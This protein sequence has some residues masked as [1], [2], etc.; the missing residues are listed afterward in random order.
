MALWVRPGATG[1]DGSQA[2]PFGTLT[3]ARDAAR[4]RAATMQG[5]LTINLE[6]GTYVLDETLQLGPEDSGRNG[7]TIVWAAAPGARP[8]VSGGTT[9]TGWQAPTDGSGVWTAKVPADLAIRQLYVD[10]K[11]AELAQGPPPPT[12]TPTA[13]G[14]TAADATMAGWTNPTDIEFVY[15]SGPSNW[16]ESRCRVAAIDG[17]AIT[18]VQPCFD[19]SSK[20]AEG[21]T[22]QV[23]GFGQALPPPKVVA[24]ARELL[25]KPGQWYLDTKA[26]T[27]SYLPLAGQD[28]GKVEVVAPKLETLVAGTGTATSPI[29]DVAFEGITFSYAGWN[30]PSGPD[31]YSPVQAGARLTG[32]DAWKNQGA[33]DGAGTTCPYM[34]FPLTPGNVTFSYGHNLAFRDDTFEHLGAAGLSLGTGTQ[35]STVT[36]SL[37]TDVSSSGIVLGGIDQPEATG[38]DL[39]TGVELSNNYLTGTGVEYQDTPAIVVGYTQKTTIRHNQIDDVPYSGISIGWGGWSERFPDNRPPLATNASGNVVANNLVFDHMKVTV[40]GGGIYANGVQGSSLTDGLVIE[41]NV[42][43]QQH[44]ISWAIYTDNGSMY[45]T[46]RNNAVWDAV[47][48]PAAAAAIPGLSPYFSFGGCGGGPISYEG[49]YSVMDDPSK[50]LA[51]A[52]SDCGGHALD[53]VTVNGNTVLKAQTDIPAALLDGAGLEASVRARLQPHP[54]PTGLPPY[55]EYP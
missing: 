29:T 5:D 12:L 55:T 50:G 33:C 48:V 2:K 14:Y 31:G 3:E 21:Q 52:S 27:L 42:V 22:L 34:A 7:H 9:V 36:G 28:P 6:D 37:F 39:V 30:D 46:V 19:N 32:K 38:A 18:M 51:S 24:N 1:G 45:M 54:V 10:G 8:V 47:Y 49:N 44:S 23:S 20:R 4:S 25:T 16:P 40:D 26:D 53:G 41:N 17:T 15:P 11:R 13:T 43:L 35:G